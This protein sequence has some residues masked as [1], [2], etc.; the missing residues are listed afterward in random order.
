MES[1]SQFEEKNQN[2]CKTW[3]ERVQRRA[4]E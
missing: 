3:G 2:G 4:E 1:Y